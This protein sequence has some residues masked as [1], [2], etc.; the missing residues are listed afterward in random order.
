[1]DISWKQELSQTSYRILREAGYIPI[2]DR[3][4]G[5][6][7][8]VYKLTGNRYPRFH[9]YIE[10]ET[11]EQLDLHLHLDNKE[12]GWGQR[13]H[14]SEYNGERVDAE[15]ERLKRWLQHFTISTNSEPTEDEQ[16]DEKGFLSRLFG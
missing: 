13:L 3:K 4:T 11:D 5:K 10:G 16:N 12:H 15:G 9:V 6:Q 7:S 14:D 2:H 1:M 8:Y